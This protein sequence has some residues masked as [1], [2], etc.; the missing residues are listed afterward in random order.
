M[1]VRANDAPSASRESLLACIVFNVQEAAER[2][3]GSTPDC[4]GF[5]VSPSMLDWGHGVG[6]KRFSQ[7]QGFAFPI[8]LSL[9]NPCMYP[10]HAEGRRFRWRQGTPEIQVCEPLKRITLRAERR[11]LLERSIGLRIENQR[12]IEGRQGLIRSVLGKIQKTL[13]MLDVLLPSGY[14]APVRVTPHRIQHRLQSGEIEAAA[15]LTRCHVQRRVEPFEHQFATHSAGHQLMIDGVQSLRTQ[16]AQTA[17]CADEIDGD[18]QIVR[19]RRQRIEQ[20]RCRQ[21][22]ATMSQIVLRG[23]GLCAR[24][25]GVERRPLLR[26]RVA[27]AP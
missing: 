25:S 16:V 21:M 17:L 19:M 15:L 23:T 13:K 7:P 20:P 3:T 6:L 8:M 10:R 2:L 24:R 9:E 27:I 12:S 11:C 5:C 26:L 14:R 18:L 4:L 22:W 1:I